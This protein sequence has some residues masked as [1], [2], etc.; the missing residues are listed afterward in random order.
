MIHP[1]LPRFIVRVFTEK[2]PFFGVDRAKRIEIAR[3]DP[4]N[5]IQVLEDGVGIYAEWGGEPLLTVEDVNFDGYADLR[6]RQGSVTGNVPHDYFLFDKVGNRFKEPPV[7]FVNPTVDPA[8]RTIRTFGKAAWFWEVETYAVRGDTFELI[9][10]EFNGLNPEK[11]KLVR[12][13]EELRNGRME[14]VSEEYE[15]LAD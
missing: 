6:A 2:D 13:M 3:G 9:R 5:L 7:M 8:T 14:V 11:G 1:D 12:R 15:E 4:Q 10:R